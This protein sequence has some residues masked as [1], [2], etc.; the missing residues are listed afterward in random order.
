MPV[1]SRAPFLLCLTCSFPALALAAPLDEAPPSFLSSKAHVGSVDVTAPAPA[2]LA[3]SGAASTGTGATQETPIEATTLAVPSVNNTNPMAPIKVQLPSALPSG[4]ARNDRITF[5]YFPADKTKVPATGA[6]GVV[7]LPYLGATDAPEFQRFARFLAARGVASA[8]MTL[9]F[10]GARSVGDAPVNHFV[11]APIDT[12]VR[13]WNQA[14]SDVSTVVTWLQGQPGLD[15][16]RIA[17][18]GISLGAI[19]LHLSMGRDARIGAGVTFLGGGDLPFIFEHS[20]LTKV[21]V[22]SRPRRLSSEEK[23]KL[24]TIDPL[25]YAGFNRPRRVLMVEGSRDLVIPPRSAQELWQ[26]LGRPPIRWIPTNHLALL[27]AQRQV[28]RASYEFLQ[29]VWRGDANPRAPKI[30]VPTLKIGFLSGLDSLVTPALTL[31]PFTLGHGLHHLP[32]VEFNVGL[33]GRGLYAGVA[34]PLSQFIDIGLARRLN[35]SKVRPY[36]SFHVGF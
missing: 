11:N 12:V 9:P 33:S 23:A 5:I 13:T 6:P 20:L 26:A 25:S 30:S 24:R 27:F 28:R 22:R 18:A 21:Y 35:G 8:V 32:V 3:A 7:M 36:L 14:A 10:H 29:S 16:T 19:V 34:T 31:E 2:L 17:G 15:R 1:F 4:D